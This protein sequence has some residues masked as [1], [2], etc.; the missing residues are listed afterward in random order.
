MRIESVASHRNGVA[1][2]PFVAAI[3]VDRVNGLPARFLVTM[4]WD[5]RDPDA[6][7]LDEATCRVIE[8]NMANAGDIGFGSNSWRGDVLGAKWAPVIKR[9][10]DDQRERNDG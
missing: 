6:E 1:G 2:Q 7:R 9:A 4:A 8:L 10:L 5:D 3:I